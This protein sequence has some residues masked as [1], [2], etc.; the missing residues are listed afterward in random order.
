M[1]IYRGIDRLIKSH[2]LINN[3]SY[4]ASE[5]KVVKIKSTNQL[6][7]LLLLTIVFA[8]FYLNIN[9][10]IEATW[11]ATL[12]ETITV[13]EGPIALAFNPSDDNLYVVAEITGNV[14]II[15]P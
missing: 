12:E 14:S 9:S 11:A 13:G 6:H 10:G 2:H 4:F 7:V 3:N 1:I 5:T 8:F 15:E